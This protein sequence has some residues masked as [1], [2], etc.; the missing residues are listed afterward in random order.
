MINEFSESLPFLQS[1]SS[2]ELIHSMLF[3]LMPILSGKHLFILNSFYPKQGLTM[4]QANYDVRVRERYALV[5]KG[6]V[7]QS[8]KESGVSTH[9]Q[10]MKVAHLGLLLLASRCIGLFFQIEANYHFWE[11][12]A[13]KASDTLF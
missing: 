6:L 11:N 3:Y 12:N 5:L 4:W 9:M 10:E 2:W 13:S 1:A 8:C 7:I